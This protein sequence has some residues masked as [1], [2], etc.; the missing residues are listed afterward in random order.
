ML[1]DR[2]STSVVCYLSSLVGDLTSILA[3][4]SILLTI[5]HYF[6]GNVDNVK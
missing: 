5:F 3:I 6:L 4:I 2:I 1:K